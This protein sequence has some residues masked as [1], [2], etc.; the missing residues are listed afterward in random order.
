M[1]CR[2]DVDRMLASSV[3]TQ[4]SLTGKLYHVEGKG[5][6]EQ[7]ERG[8]WWRRRRRMR[9]KRKRMESGRV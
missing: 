8:R 2:T 3:A 9:K 5:V 6:G 1:E 7:A 4:R